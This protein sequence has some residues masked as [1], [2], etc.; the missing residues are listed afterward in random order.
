MRASGSWANIAG[1]L[2]LVS[3]DDIVERSV[4]NFAAA[5]AE[6]GARIA[7]A[8]SAMRGALA[9]AATAK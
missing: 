8:V 4:A 9:A 6:Y 1:S 3:K 7:G 2:S 5:D